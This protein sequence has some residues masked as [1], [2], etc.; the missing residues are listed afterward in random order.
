MTN[1]DPQPE[2]PAAQPVTSGAYRAWVLFILVVVYTFNFIDRQITGILAVPIKADLNLAD[3]QLSL[4]G[5][6]AFALFYTFLGIPI[7]M[8]ADRTSRTWIMTIALSI[9]SLMTAV[10][11][12]AQNFW[13]LFLARLGVGVGE[14]GGVAPAYSLISD[15][16][17]P[18]QRARALSIYSFGIPIGSALGIILGGILTD[19]IGWRAAFIIVG[20]AGL[21][22]API[23]RLTMREP[24]RG[25]YDS[26]TA[27]KSPAKLSA[28]IS[29]L[30]KKSS[31]WTLAFG[32]ASSSM[33]GYGLIFWLPSFFVRSFGDQLPEFMGF[34]PGF[35]LPADPTPISYAAYFYGTILFFGG[36][37]GIWL[38]GALADRFGGKNKGAYALIP[39]WA[40]VATIPF[41]LVGV[42]V[43]NLTFVFISFVGLQALSLVWLGPV[44]TAFQHLVGPNMR[45]TASAIFLFINNLIG[46]GLGNFIIGLISDGLR[47]RFGDES[48]RYA[49]LSGF[50]FYVLAAVLLFI[51]AP[52]LKRD[53][54][55]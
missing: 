50:G 55:G 53:W 17:P 37:I 22:I 46:I 14:A 7:A 29:L 3:W 41:F 23:F 28:V 38:G 42:L 2:Q 51:T 35:L 26:Q 27:D 30:R 18:H 39:A 54:V 1:I 21:A 44:L 32:A 43:D 45:A 40:F 52:K 19:I 8:F 20:L 25:Q 10:C 9:W 16:F 5:G 15:Y 6:M 34:L 47:E 12:F 49:I 36:M 31:F 13:H 24:V 11:G 48:L 4:M 33:M